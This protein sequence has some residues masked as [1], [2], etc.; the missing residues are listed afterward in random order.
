MVNFPRRAT[1]EAISAIVTFASSFS[2]PL[3]R[4]GI[5]VGCMASRMFAADR[6]FLAKGGVLCSENK[7]RVLDGLIDVQAA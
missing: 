5:N 2:R 3:P 1:S 7:L 6:A 4:A